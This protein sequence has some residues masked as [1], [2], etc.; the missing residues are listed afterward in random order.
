M[1]SSSTDVYST[2]DSDVDCDINPIEALPKIST[3]LVFI[4]TFFTFYLYG[5]YWLYSRSI[6]LNRTH[7]SVVIGKGFINIIPTLWLGSLLV[8]IADDLYTLNL[9]SE[10]W[11][12]PVSIALNIAIIFWC[13][14]I[15]TRLS[16]I[17][18]NNGISD[19]QLSGLLTFVLGPL[20]LNYKVV[21]MIN[22]YEEQQNH[23]E[24]DTKEADT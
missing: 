10:Q 24:A 23:S 1:D 3:W 12:W 13:F 18:R 4:F 20:Y 8:E 17:R 7:K 5:V 15:K 6:I 2:P 9:A 19:I 21:E 11:S 16:W 14:S 22:L